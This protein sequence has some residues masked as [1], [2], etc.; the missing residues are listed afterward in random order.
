M[1][2]AR[3]LRRMG[4]EVRVLG[5][6]DGP[7]PATFVSPLG[8]SLPTASNGS[9]A[10]IAPDPIAQ[11]RT[12][13]LLRDEEFDV[14]CTS[15]SHSL[16]GRPRRRSSC[17]RRRWSARSTR[18]ASRTATGLL[19]A[20]LRRLADNLSHRVAVS[21]DAHGAGP[22][23]HRWRVRGAVQRGRVAQVPRSSA[24]SDCGRAACSSAVG[25]RSA[26]VSTCCSA[27]FADLPTDVELLIGSDGP[28]TQTVARIRGGEPAD[29][30]ARSAD[31]RGQDR[32]SHRRFG[33]LRTVAARR[34]LRRGP[35]RGDGSGNTG[36]RQLARRL[37]QRRDAW[38]RRPV[39]RTGR[40]RRSSPRRSAASSTSP[41]WPTGCGRAATRA[42]R[43]SR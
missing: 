12:L 10:P 37:P 28:D 5:P 1:G 15:T 2:L 23:F 3:E 38:Q 32:V 11:F 21:K 29:R 20:P 24:P 6:C 41:A 39:V 22:G 30:V 17:T 19:D 33:V 31:R 36:G 40:C 25:T 35:D 4:Y 43:I 16:P 26:R 34:I 42:P 13:R 9:I 18:P 27:V 8:N 7:P 14:L